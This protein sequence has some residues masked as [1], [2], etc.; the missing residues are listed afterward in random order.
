MGDRHPRSESNAA[1]RM[2]EYRSILDLD[3]NALRRLIDEN[4]DG[5]LV[6]DADG[7]TQF[8]NPAA[9]GLFGRTADEIIGRVFGFPIVGDGC[10][11][12]N[13]MRPG[14]ERCI[15]E[16]RVVQSSWN[17]ETAFIVSLRDVTERKMLEEQ[18]RQSQK[19]EALGRLAG[20]ISHDF[21]NMLTSILCEASLL[22]DHL[23]TDDPRQR[24]ANQIRNTASRAAD[25]TEQLL[26]FS[27][28]RLVPTEL[29]DVAAA[30]REMERVL[31]RI[32]GEHIQLISLTGVQDATVRIG[33]SS[34]DQI[35]LNLVLNARD[36]MQSHG[37]LTI[38]I[39]IVDSD[40]RSP[41]NTPLADFVRLSVEDTGCGIDPDVQTRIF[42]PFF[43]TKE[44]GEGTGLGLAVVYG[45]VEQAGG[46]VTVESQPGR[47]T[48]F[49]VLLP[50][51]RVPH[52]APRDL[53]RELPLEPACENL[54]RN[55]LLAED[56]DAVREVLAEILKT[57]GYHVTLARNGR[58]A[59]EYVRASKEMTDLLITDVAMPDM[60]GPELVR[61]FRIHYPNT[62]VLFISGYPKGES[63]DEHV[64][65]YRSAFLGKPFTRADLLKALA[66]LACSNAAHPVSARESDLP[67]MHSLKGSARYTPNPADQSPHA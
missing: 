66:E 15:A 29:I 12:V 23:D 2:P 27:R 8:A 55:I 50:R 16:M 56:E 21:N 42:D 5:I 62:P 58:D 10:F 61:E 44:N 9:E 32:I 41:E 37:T 34:L 63:L 4:A 19:M 52:A 60:S 57:E 24:A 54:P 48:T 43:T 30:T 7:T 35:L 51:V 64:D 59:L 13:I 18:L 26:T 1:S 65:W 17:N 28:K 25:L 47:G 45:I 53:K 22:A 20:G 39:S 46:R 3:K 33:R 11:E 36:A 49:S 6:M 67:T 31:R 38:G 40:Q 14:G